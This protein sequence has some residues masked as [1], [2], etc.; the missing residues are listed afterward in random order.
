M[1]FC[2]IELSVDRPTPCGYPADPQ[3]VGEHLRKRR[4]D[5]EL[6]QKEVAAEIGVG[7]SSIANWESGRSSPRLTHWP[8]ILAFLG[9]DPRPLPPTIGQKLRRHREGLGLSILEAAAMMGVNS[10]T[11]STWERMPDE[12]HSHISIPPIADFLGYNPLPVPQS[13]VEYI[14][15]SR[16]SAGLSQK[17]MARQLGVCL[18]VMSAWERGKECPPPDMLQRIQSVVSPSDI[19]YPPRCPKKPWRRFLALA[20]QSAEEARAPKPRTPYPAEV[21]TLGDHIR[22]GR[23]DLGLTQQQLAERLDVMAITVRSWEL[24]HSKPSPANMPKIIACFGPCPEFHDGSLGEQLRHARLRLGLTQAEVAD[25]TGVSRE[26]ISAWEND[27][28]VSH[29][30]SIVLRRLQETAGLF[31]RPDSEA[32]P[33]A[34]SG[35]NSTLFQSTPLC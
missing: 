8:D 5:L 30:I 6:C 3:T 2:H 29:K 27:Q 33:N 23:M 26:S 7:K 32:I 25:L 24:N 34:G 13:I 10:S 20:E 1:P 22:K 15:F 28:Y 9:Y 4:M 16:Y 35:V 19:A 17:A 12:K 31:A 18:Q 21:K 14:L 11:L